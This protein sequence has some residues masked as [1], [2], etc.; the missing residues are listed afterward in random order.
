[1]HLPILIYQKELEN[2]AHFRRNCARRALSAHVLLNIS[3]GLIST[4]VKLPVDQPVS[5]LQNES[6][7]SDN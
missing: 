6:L 7:E 4:P 3:L 2:H 5:F 1:M